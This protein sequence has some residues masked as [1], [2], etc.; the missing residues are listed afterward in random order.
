MDYMLH[1]DSFL[2]AIVAVWW[3][4]LKRKKNL[5]RVIGQVWHMCVCSCHTVSAQTCWNTISNVTEKHL[6]A[7]EEFSLVFVD[8][9]VACGHFAI[10]IPSNWTQ[11]ISGVCQTIGSCQSNTHNVTHMHTKRKRKLTPLHARFLCQITRV[12]SLL[13]GGLLH[14]VKWMRGWISVNLPLCC[15][16]IRL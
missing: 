8:D 2:L 4:L 3:C 10:L 14:M 15:T 5:N 1:L 7:S 12:N 11:E 6:L 16:V 13:S 9:G